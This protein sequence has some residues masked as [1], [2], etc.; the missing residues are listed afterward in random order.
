MVRLQEEFSVLSQFSISADINP[1]TNP[2]PPSQNLN[3]IF[4]SP[5][6]LQSASLQLAGMIQMIFKPSSD[7]SH[8]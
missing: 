7:G 6:L 8:G 2:P 5:S 3:C 1:K 4:H